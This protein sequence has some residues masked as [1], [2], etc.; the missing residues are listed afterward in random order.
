MAEERPLSDEHHFRR[1]V[2]DPYKPLEPDLKQ[3]G[4]HFP[5]LSVWYDQ[6]KCRTYQNGES[7]LGVG[8]GW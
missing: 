5:P 7:K 8:N 1:T 4:D 6:T 2:S 3:L